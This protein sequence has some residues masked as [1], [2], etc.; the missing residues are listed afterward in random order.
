MSRI[1]RRTDIHGVVI[2]DKPQGLSSQQVVSRVKAKFNVAKAGHTGTLDPIATGMLPICVNHAT[3]FTEL[4]LCD[5]KAYRVTA[6]LGTTTETGDTEGAEIETKAVPDF[7]SADIVACLESC[8]GTQ[9]QV[10]PKY[11]ALKYQGKPLYYY[12]RQGIEV[13]RKERE[14]TI[15]SI[16][17]LEWQAPYISFEARVSKG[18]YIRSLV[19]TIGEKLETGAHMTALRRLWV[20]AFR[21]SEM[22]ALD[23]VNEDSSYLSSDLMLKQFEPLQL[24]WQLTKRLIYGQIC[25]LQQSDGIYKLYTPCSIFLGLGQVESQVLRAYRLLPTAPTIDMVNKRILVD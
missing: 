12:A 14:I 13:P 19:E 6:K 5:D 23:A 17:L 24:D 20:S 22:I 10:A 15:Q 2:I 25:K 18:T 1:P 21:D 16:Q 4:L 9:I 8:V 7:S 11:S 3:R